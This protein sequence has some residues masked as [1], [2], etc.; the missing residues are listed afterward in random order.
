IWKKIHCVFTAE[1]GISLRRVYFGGNNKADL[2]SRI[3]NATI[4]DLT[5]V[6]GEEK[7]PNKSEMDKHTYHDLSADNGLVIKMPQTSIPY[8]FEILHVLFEKVS[9]ALGYPASLTKLLT[10]MVFLDTISDLYQKTTLKQRD[11]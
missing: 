6:Y 9:E 2:D 4:I 5:K 7:E 3:D 10:A 8:N 11:I 1:E